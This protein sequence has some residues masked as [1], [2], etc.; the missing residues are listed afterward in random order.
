M[1]TLVFFS[2]LSAFDTSFMYL[3]Y[4]EKNHLKEVDEDNKRKV[5]KFLESLIRYKVVS[6]IL[7]LLLIALY[8]KIVNFN[9]G[10]FLGSSITLF[11]ISVVLL[12]VLQT[13][14]KVIAK[15]DIYKTLIY[16]IDFIDVLMIL[17]YP[18]VVIIE[19]LYKQ[20]N[21]I[22]NN[23]EDIGE[24]DLT[25]EDIKNIISYA[26]NNEVEKEEKEMIHSIFTFTDTTVKE[27]MTPR[28]SIVA[29]D[30]EEILNDVW[31]DI[32]EHEFSRI[33]LYKE[34]IDDI[35]GVMYTKDLL[36]YKDRNIKLKNLIKDVVYVPET[37][38]LT[39]M[40]EF[41]RQKQQHMAIIIDEYGGT[42]GLITIEDLLEE[43]VGEIRDEYDI[44]EENFKSISENV[45]ELLGETLV[46]EIN[47]KYELNIE[48]SEEYDTIS[49]Y[50]QY[51][52]ERVANENDKV[53]NDD[54]IIQVLKVDNKKIEKV[55]LIIK[56]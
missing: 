36:K 46:D 5:A 8:L 3:N 56:R 33:P 41:F 44:E 13:F 21:N 34:S 42:L 22:F 30:Q 27:I 1:I 6:N 4:I 14:I 20:I 53:I 7:N 18:L 12:I 49:G 52:L 23:G 43:I 40:L 48:E 37:V 45:Y 29:Y 47:E 10:I 19:F 32:I 28:T 55:K 26:N 17:L 31:D 25:E 38:T 50:I 2:I 51:K 35:C 54:Y 24:R 9:L 39:D 16:T 15:I 11:V